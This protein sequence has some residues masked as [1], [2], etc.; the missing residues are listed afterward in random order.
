MRVLGGEVEFPADVDDVGVGEAAAAGLVDAAA[1]LVDLGVAVGV[2]EVVEGDL[3]EDV[4]LLDGVA[5]VAGCGPVGVL[6]AGL[7]GC[8]RRRGGERGGVGGGGGRGG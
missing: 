4:A 8:R 1:G 5:L 6:L 3:A 7:L 2:A